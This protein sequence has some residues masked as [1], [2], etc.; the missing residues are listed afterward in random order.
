MRGVVGGGEGSYLNAIGE[1][2]EMHSTF[3]VSG[4]LGVAK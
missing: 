3:K 4:V 2:V 1:I